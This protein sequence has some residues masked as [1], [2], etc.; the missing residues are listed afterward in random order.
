MTRR[1]RTVYSIIGVGLATLAWSAFT[2]RVESQSG[3]PPQYTAQGELKLP[4]GFES[5][6]FVGS[7]LG[8]AYR[9]DPP[10]APAMMAMTNARETARA[11]AQVFHNVYINPEAYAHFAA[12]KEFPDPTVLVMEVFTAA[13]KQQQPVLSTGVFN[14][15]RIGF[16]V[17]VKDTR[18]PPLQPAPPPPAVWQYY[19]FQDPTD[20]KSTLVT[21]VKPEETG[22]CQA[23]HQKH[24]SK[25]NV[26]VQFYP[27]LRK[28]QQ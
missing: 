13:D 28:V 5:W 10:P 18:R 2:S 24:A 16:E 1:I 4:V 23:C 26:W 19:T 15:E 25:D 12:T 11:D 9:R 20:P 14:G 27:T 3:A 21:V 8:M 17:A 6:V 7:N 22:F